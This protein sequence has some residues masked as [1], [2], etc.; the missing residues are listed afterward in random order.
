MTTVLPLLTA[1]ALSASTVPAASPAEVELRAALGDA[2][3]QRAALPPEAQV[4]VGELRIADRDLLERALRLSGVELPPGERG[5]SRV[6]ARARLSLRGGGEAWTWVSA[7]VEVRVPALI[8]V[9]PLERGRTIAP[10]DVAVALRPL[11][12]GLLTEGGAA[13]GKAPRRDFRAGEALDDAWLVA[14]S[15][16]QRGD[17]VEVLIADGALS[18]RAR[19]ETLERGAVGELVRLRV[20]ATGRI[21]RGRVVDATTVEVRP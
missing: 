18:V 8:A 17:S 10:D 4:E 12:P 20:G 2:V 15:V 16:V 6:S 5:L 13:V 21:V 7:P 9:Q 19:G 11:R 3:R 1:L 14:P